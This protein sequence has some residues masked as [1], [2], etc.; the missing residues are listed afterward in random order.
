VQAETK[1]AKSSVD[2]MNNKIWFWRHKE[3]TGIVR[4]HT[5]YRKPVYVSVKQ[6]SREAC[7]WRNCVRN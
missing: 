6:L 4:K 7:Y 3:D 1:G 5:G 2:C